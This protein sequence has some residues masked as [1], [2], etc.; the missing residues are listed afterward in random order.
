MWLSDSDCCLLIN[1]DKILDSL[2]T[3]LQDARALQGDLDW[4]AKS[5]RL[6]QSE[7]VQERLKTR[8]QR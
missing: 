2:I 1:A 5:Q 8:R 3:L 6:P 4:N 7:F